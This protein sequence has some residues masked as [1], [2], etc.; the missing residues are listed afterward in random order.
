LVA[1]GKGLLHDTNLLREFR[2]HGEILRVECSEL[3]EL[4]VSHLSPEDAAGMIAEHVESLEAAAQKGSVDCV[5]HLM[6]KSNR[7]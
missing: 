6:T 4:D 5:C 7:D 2:E 3:L 1:G